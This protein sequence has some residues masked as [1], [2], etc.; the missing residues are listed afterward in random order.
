[1]F[2]LKEGTMKITDMQMSDQERKEAAQGP[3]EAHEEAKYPYGLKLHLEEDEL[4]KLGMK[5]LPKTGTRFVVH[6]IAKVSGA[7]EQEQDG[8]GKKRHLELQVTHMGADEVD[9]KD[10]D[11][12]KR[13]PVQKG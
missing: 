10:E 9:E 5:E 6:G 1:M 8:G 11:V 4:G 13:Y 12:A 3:V 7:H 2:S